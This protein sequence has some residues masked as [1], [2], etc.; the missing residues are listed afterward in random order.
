MKNKQSNK[1]TIIAKILLFFGFLFAVINLYGQDMAQ[2]NGSESA[3]VQEEGPFVLKRESSSSPAVAQSKSRTTDDAVTAAVLA[4][5]ATSSESAKDSSYCKHEVSVWGAGGLST[6]YYSTTFG[7]R[8]PKL[9]GGFGLGYTYYFDQNF[10]V[11]IG[12][13]LAFYNAKMKVNGLTDS[14]ATQDA[15]GMDI[16]YNTAIKD[17]EETQRMTNVNIPLAFQYQTGNTHKFYASL[18]FKLGI[19]VSGKYK[20]SDGATITASGFYD[21]WQQELYD[22]TDLGY[23]T[24]IG[25]ESK[26][27]IDFSLSYM[28]TV[29]AGVKWKLNRMLSLYTGAYFEYG[30]NDVVDT[31]D[32]KFVAYNNINPQDYNVNS[33]LTSEYTRNGRTESFTERVSPLAVGL[34]VRLGV[35]LC[36][37]GKEKVEKPAPAPAPVKVK[38]VTPAP[39]PTPAPA[40]VAPAP[41]KPAPAQ[42]QPESRKAKARAIIAARGQDDDDDMEDIKTPAPV[43]EEDLRRAVSEYG[44]G[45]KGMITIELEGYELDQATLSPKMEQVLD[46]KIAQIKKT[47]GDN[48]RIVCEGHTCDVGKADYN[49]KLGLKRANVVRDYL[50][51]KGYSADRVQAISKGQTSPIVPNDTEANRKK[52]RRVVL[53]IRDL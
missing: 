13:E 32:N 49:M 47:Y 44:S 4:S 40:K 28:G 3:P 43:M 12:A 26:D 7:D 36:S 51:K 16:L 30:F 6:L 48:I 2:S 23:G 50:I 42:V 18:G 39:A 52:N 9:G 41:V 46:E 21:R 45:V 15:D 25:K 1:T 20:V 27:D 19:P 11:L 5:T 14:Y 22:Q 53:I 31:H 24:F 34:K 17:Y 29:E 33:T 37:S 35:D 8:S 10:G 38:P